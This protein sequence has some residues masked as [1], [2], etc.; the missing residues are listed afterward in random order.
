MEKPY[1]NIETG[2]S[3][4]E[5]L[6]EAKELREFLG[7]HIPIENQG[8]LDKAT[9]KQ[10][11]QLYLEV[12]NSYPS[13]ESF[14]KILVEQL[15][16]SP[17]FEDK[18]K[19]IQ[20]K[21]LE[22]II[23]SNPDDPLLIKFRQYLLEKLPVEHLNRRLEIMA[24]K[25]IQDKIKGMSDEEITTFFKNTL[26]ELSLKK[27]PMVLAREEAEKDLLKIMLG[28]MFSDGHEKNE[29]KEELMA[30]IPVRDLLYAHKRME[31]GGSGNIYGFH[32]SNKKYEDFVSVSKL[33]AEVLIG[34]ESVSVPAG[35]VHCNL[36]Y[37][38]L[39][40]GGHHGGIPKY[41]YI[42]EVPR[43]VMGTKMN[44]QYYAKSGDKQWLT[45]ANPLPIR[46]V[47]KL[48]PEIIEEVGLG[49]E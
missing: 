44:E 21:T 4:G 12:L 17:K 36:N 31:D 26:F 48:T 42:V 43:F 27:M 16:D 15:P 20:S 23:N 30:G 32:T 35:Y 14:Q 25:S 47:I 46:G 28:K 41:L 33:P 10:L 2:E 40:K 9:L 7:R 18:K 19:D 6:L 11:F 38:K 13:L 5:E 29:L 45:S 34:G 3:V 8:F 22:E 49:F 1:E 24:E 39:F 37:S